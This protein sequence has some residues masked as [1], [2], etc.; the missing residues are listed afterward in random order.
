MQAILS[1]TGLVKSY[2]RL[3]A[4]DGVDIAVQPGEALGIVGPNGAGKTTLFGAL[5]GAFPLSAGEI[6][7]DGAVITPLPAP[8]RCALGIAR[9]YQVPRPFLGMTVF[10]NVQV[11]ARAGGDLKTEASI[12]HAAQILGATGL[13]AMANRPA[14]ALGL[15]DRKRLELARALATRPRVILLDEIG[16]G[17]TEGELDVLVALI[18]TLKAQGLTIVWIEHILHA[19]LRVIDRL[20]CMA[21]GRILAQGSPRA[22]MDDAQVRAAYL[23]S[24]PE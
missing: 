12:D 23:G 24:D 2:G 21:E 8:R 11:A 19:L 13:R 15:L 3:R 10:E 18:L 16:G 7:L 6:R 17:L 20:V 4:V 1:G 22:V 5:A 14:G 9:T